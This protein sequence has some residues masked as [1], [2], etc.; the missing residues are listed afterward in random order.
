MSDTDSWRLCQDPRTGDGLTFIFYMN[1]AEPD[2]MC[3]TGIL[4]YRC[5]DPSNV[6]GLIKVLK[7][8]VQGHGRVQQIFQP[9]GISF[10]REKS[11]KW[12]GV[13]SNFEL[14]LSY[15]C[16]NDGVVEDFASKILG[17]YELCHN[18]DKTINV[19]LQQG[20]FFGVCFPSRK[21]VKK[22]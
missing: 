9:C 12:M 17:I 4:Q 19:I 16:F 15:K 22:Y 1:D 11:F 7:Q 20:I 8:D 2:T 6:A 5:S 14:L 21:Y 18:S 3:L 13:N 10:V